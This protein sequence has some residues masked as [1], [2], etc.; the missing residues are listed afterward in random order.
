ME[1]T[2]MK[3]LVIVGIVAA[4][5]LWAAKVA[6]AHGG[7]H[8]GRA[9]V[10]RAIEGALDAA[11]ASP[12][13]RTAI[14]AARDHVLAT[15]HEASQDHH[16]QMD[17]A[18]ALLSAP[19]LDE[20]AI[21]AH[22]AVKQAAV[23]KIAD[24]VVQALYDAHAALTPPQ[25]KAVVD[26]LRAERAQHEE[27]RMHWHEG[28]FRRMFERRSEAAMEAISASAAQRASLT[29]AR[30]RVLAAFKEMRPDGSHL[31]KLLDLFTADTL[32]KAQIASL[33]G[34]VTARMNK[35]GDTLTQALAEVHGQLSAEQR[36][37]LVDW[38]KA[39]RPEHHDD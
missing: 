28:F 21:A 6:V 10:A 26:Y 16:Q 7:G 1:A 20:K 35:V 2:T 17:E 27:H 19:T 14:E 34:E 3:R 15:F 24:A 25:R 37:K 23:Q 29:A 36:T 5:A 31:D 30:D 39:H 12:A 32:D 4:A 18:L 9:M 22:R 33:R 13:Q 38:I 8:R 11:K